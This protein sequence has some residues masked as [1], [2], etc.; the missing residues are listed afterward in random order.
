MASE[1]KQ[2]AANIRPFIMGLLLGG[3]AG[4][5]GMHLHQSNEVG[6]QGTP[7]APPV[8]AECQPVQPQAADTTSTPTKDSKDFEF[9]GVLENAPVT[10]ARPDLEQPPVPPAMAQAPPS[11]TPRPSPASG[12]AFYLQIASFR[13]AADAD[14][15]K[16]RIALAG[17]PAAVVAMDIPDKGTYYRVRV[18]PFNSQEELAQA[19]AQLAQGSIDLHSAFVVR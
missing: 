17:E 14:A 18:G 1:R 2:S 15:L 4:M 11:T 10:P 6:P 3:L 19:K 7:G 13:A 16:A 12:K 8:K 9:Y 5:L